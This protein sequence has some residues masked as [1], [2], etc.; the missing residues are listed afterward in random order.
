MK[1]LK[2]VDMGNADCSAVFNAETVDDVLKQAEAHA[3]SAHNVVTTPE[4][5]E[6]AKSLIKDE[7]A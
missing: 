5:V 2:C 1:I 4:M 6:K 7:G 3:K